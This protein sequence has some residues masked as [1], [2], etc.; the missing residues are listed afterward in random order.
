MKVKFAK[1]TSVDVWKKSK[2]E[3]ETVNKEHAPA[4]KWSMR[5][6]QGLE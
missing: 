5:L 4:A 2:P 6:L 3:L 1:T